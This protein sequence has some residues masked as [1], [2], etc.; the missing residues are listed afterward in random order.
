MTPTPNKTQ[1]WILGAVIFVMGGCGLAYE[2]TFSRIASDLLGNSVQQWAVVIAIMLFCMGMGAEVQRFIPARRVVSAM[3]GSQLLLALLGGFGPLLML[4]AFSYAPYQFGLVHYSLISVIGLLIGFEIPLITRI[5]EGYSEDIR[6]N[7]ARVLK[8]DYIGALAGGLLWIFVLPKFFSLHQTAYILAFL[9]VAATLLCWFFF[10]KQTRHP[11]LILAGI[12]VTTGALGVGVAKS[13]RWSLHAEQQLYL[14]RVIFSEST[15]YQHIVLTKDKNSNLRCYINGHIQFSSTD[16][17]IYHE[18]LVHPPMQLLTHRKRIL[19]L[20][21]GDGLAVRELLKYPDVEE[22]VLVDLD[23]EMTRLAAEQ[24]DLVGINEGSLTDARVQTI[25]NQAITSDGPYQL[26]LPHQ[27]R[28]IQP[29]NPHSPELQVINLDAIA[30]VQQATGSFDCIILDFP[31][32]SSP[33]LAKLYSLPFYQALKSKLNADG[34]IVQQSTSPYRAKEAFLC[35]G[36][37]LRA[38]GYSA[39]PYHDHVPSFGEWGWW[40]AA[41]QGTQSEPELRQRLSKVDELP[42]DLRYLTPDLIRASLYFGKGSLDTAHE[43]I[44]TLTRPSV[45]EYYLQGWNY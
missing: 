9:T 37:T 11:A 38:A 20:G 3:L 12:V 26:E 28:T 18:M 40:I 41:H 19:V 7:L 32:P 34:V 14:D 24:A 27:R 15:Q 21:G 16:E 45:L 4:L 33:D 23:P 8:M 13:H 1:G 30:Y 10:R 43:T 36:R 5:N 29:G 31:D 42:Q 25:S 17:F 2:Y 44:S 6:N 22:I 35:I 39:I